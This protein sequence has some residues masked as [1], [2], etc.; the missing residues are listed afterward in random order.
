MIAKYSNLTLNKQ[1]EAS[2]FRRRLY[3]QQLLQMSYLVMKVEMNI[4]GWPRIKAAD[5]FKI[6]IFNILT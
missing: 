2:A 3:K 6:N 1:V 4:H 5:S